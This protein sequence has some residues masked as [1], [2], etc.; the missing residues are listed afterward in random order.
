M[1]QMW[2]MTV[3]VV[4]TVYPR[5]RDVASS[6]ADYLLKMKPHPMEIDSLALLLARLTT[7]QIG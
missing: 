4:K 7:N 6:E 2:S 3:K 1:T 5:V